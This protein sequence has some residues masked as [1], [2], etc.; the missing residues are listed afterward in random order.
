MKLKRTVSVETGRDNSQ[1]ESETFYF[2]CLAD[3]TP[4]QC[5]EQWTAVEAWRSKAMMSDNNNLLIFFLQLL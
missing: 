1:C 5:F 3:S 4:D 2:N